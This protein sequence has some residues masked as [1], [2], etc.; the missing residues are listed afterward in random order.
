MAPCFFHRLRKFLHRVRM[1][2]PMNNILRWRWICALLAFG[3]AATLWFP[4]RTHAQAAGIYRELFSGLDRAN[5][6]LWQ[7]TNDARFLN[8]TPSSTTILSNFRTELNMADDY[9]QRLRAFAIAPATGNYTFGI[10]SDEVSQLFLSTDENPANKRLIAY[11]DPRVQPDNFDTFS[12]QQSSNI[13]LQAGQ[14]YYLEALHKEAN[15]IDHLSVR[16]RLPN[17]TYESPIPG[18]RLVYEIPP[19]LTDLPAPVTIEEGRPATWRAELANFLPQSYRWQRNGVD[20]PNATNSSFTIPSV[21]LADQGA[22][23]RVFVTNVFGAT[24][25]PEVSLTVVRDTNAPVVTLVAN[26]N[27]TNVLVTFSEPVEPA[28]GLWAQNYMIP[29]VVVQDAAFGDDHGTVILA[30]SPLTLQTSYTISV[31][32]VRDLA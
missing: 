25:T 31:S 19:L 10:A 24:N 2:A 4:L 16:W 17:N 13:V 1:S 32:G 9:G 8:N 14:R 11:V 23:F 18:T 15:L 27:R 29:G 3:A 30:T 7:L 22:L 12:S 6:S 21:S 20:I 26:G 28:S 5:N